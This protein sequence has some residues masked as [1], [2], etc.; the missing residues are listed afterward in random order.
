M[1]LFYFILFL[2]ALIVPQKSSFVKLLLYLYLFCSKFYAK[3]SKT[4][5]V[6]FLFVPSVRWNV[7]ILFYTVPLCSNCSQ[8]ILLCKNTPLPVN[9]CSKFDAKCSKTLFLIFL[10]VPSVRWKVP[11]L[12]YTVPLCSNCSP[13]ILL[14]KTAPLPV[15][16]GGRVG[17]RPP[18][19]SLTNTAV[20]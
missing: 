7:P 17:S 6:I 10:F 15:Q 11:M 12:F 8:E 19:W 9:I 20:D 4:L 2:F 5:F 18:P 14:S 1:F 13:E 3:C 16:R